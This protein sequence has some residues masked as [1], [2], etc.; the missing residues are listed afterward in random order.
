MNP[1][2]NGSGMQIDGTTLL[3][4]AARQLL[5]ERE[6]EFFRRRDKA[7]KTSD[8][9]DL[10]D[11]RV[12]S[13]RLRE[14]VALFAPCY[15]AG[16]TARLLKELKKVTRL[17]GDIRNTD[18][19]ILFFTSLADTVA[20]DCRD[21]LERIALTFQKNREKEQRQLKA[22]L[23]EIA[24]DSFRDRCRR[25]TNAP[26]LFSQEGNGVDLFTPLLRFAGNALDTRLQAVIILLPAATQ[27][28][29]VEAQHLLRIA[30]KHFRY[31]VEIL[32]SLFGADFAE[33]HETLKRYQELLGR[34]HDL[35]VFSGVIREY[36]LLAE[37]ERPIQDAIA[38]KR[39]ALFTDFSAMLR[40]APFEQIG[41]RLRKSL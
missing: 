38:A 20:A 10:H 34:M 26:S 2:D 25:V 39:H 29:E 23:Q 1:P 31:R 11:L 6:E 16:K 8:P 37:A 14:G 40:S 9:E 35:D 28:G 4:I 7:L 19:A 3:W 24:S 13:R 22:G 17:L 27:E 12:A 32:S 15:P 36:G 41:A 18:E 33:I 21:D 30:V 5:S